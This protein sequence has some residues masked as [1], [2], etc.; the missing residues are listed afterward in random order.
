[1]RQLPSTVV[2]VVVFFCF[3]IVFMTCNVCCN[4][5]E[6]LAAGDGV[7]LMSSGLASQSEDSVVI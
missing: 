7:M 4:I 2:I 6:S 3:T 1:M 5:T